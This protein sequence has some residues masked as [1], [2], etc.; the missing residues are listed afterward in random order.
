MFSIPALRRTRMSEPRLMIKRGMAYTI[1]GISCFVTWIVARIDGLLHLGSFPQRTF[2]E[3]HGFHFIYCLGITILIRLFIGSSENHKKTCLLITLVAILGSTAVEL[4]QYFEPKRVVDIW[5]IA[6][7]ATGCISALIFM[8][9][10]GSPWVKAKP[11]KE[12]F[13]QNRS[14]E[15]M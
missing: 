10:V 2:M 13:V 7:Q 12:Q 15:R 4:L 9:I 5:D 14:W 8:L 11:I 1:T 3:H 6:F